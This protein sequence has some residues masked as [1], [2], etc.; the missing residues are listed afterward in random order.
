[1]LTTTV[2]QSRRAW[3]I[4]RMWPAWSAPI[5]RA[6]PIV[7]FDCRASARGRRRSAIDAIS[8]AAI[9][10]R[11]AADRLGRR[12]R[13]SPGANIVDVGF[14]GGHD[15]VAQPRVLFDEGRRL[16]EQPQ[17]VVADEHLP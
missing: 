4:R 9:S 10:R 14:G 12:R 5:G 15:F 6:N 13:E 11:T 2:R 8:S 7:A 17:H 1:M 3:S 16:L